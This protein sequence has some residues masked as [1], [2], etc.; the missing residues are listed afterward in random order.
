MRPKRITV[1]LC[2]LVGSVAA[3]ASAGAETEAGFV[4]G[5]PQLG[6]A[7]A[8]DD[9]VLEIRRFVERM[10][11]RKTVAHL[12]AGVKIEMKTGTIGPVSS[13][14]IVPVLETH[15]TRI[16]VTKVVA[17]RVDGRMV[18]LKTLLAELE[19]P[20]PVILA[21]QHQLDPLFS[22]MFKPE[23]L[24]LRF[25]VEEEDVPATIPPSEKAE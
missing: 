13:T 19:R 15:R 7:V 4:A 9:R 12:P 3:Q 11:T 10:V 20:T 14:K 24:V 1:L 16:D 2:A 5:P 23:S 18:S 8:V 21:R 22:K 17:C 6:V 25:L